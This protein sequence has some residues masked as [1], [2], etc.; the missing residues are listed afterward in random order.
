[1]KLL[2]AM[3]KSAHQHNTDIKTLQ[4][5]GRVFAS[6]KYH[7]S[8]RPANVLIQDRTLT[9]PKFYWALNEERWALIKMLYSTDDV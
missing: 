3:N 8:F 1:M 2:K 7:F 5:C 9:G 4:S 6:P